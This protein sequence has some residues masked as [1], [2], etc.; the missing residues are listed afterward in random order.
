MT[1]QPQGDGWWQ[2]SDGRWYPPEQHPG[3]SGAGAGATGPGAGGTGTGVGGGMP[4]GD[5]GAPTP[6]GEQKSGKGK[7]VAAL[8][9][10]LLLIGAGVGAFVLLGGDD[11]DD[12][13]AT[14]S[15][16]AGSNTDIGD[17]TG[18]L[19][20]DG[21]IEFDTEYTDRLDGDRT[22]ARYTLDAPNGAIMTLEVANV[23]ES[24]R[25]VYVT[26]ESAGT[27]FAG[28][29]VQP[30]A[31][32]AE[33]II[34]DDT[35]EATFDLIFTEGPAEFTFGVGLEIQDDAGQGGDAGAEFASAFDIDAGQEVAAMLGGED[36]T[37]HFTV[38]IEPGT[39]L[40]VD[41]AVDR[42]S[43][44]A[45][46]MTVMLDGDRLF[47]ERVQPGADT[48][49]SMLL[50]DTDT[51]TLEVIATEGAADYTFTVDFGAQSEGGEDGDAPG[52]L[53]DARSIDISSALQGKVGDRD[54]AD[55]FT[56]TAPGPTFSVTGASDS[57]S[58]RNYSLTVQDA[59][60]GRVA[61]FRVQ[62]GA[63]NTETIEV[64]PGS[65][66][67]LIVEEGPASYTISVG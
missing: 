22:E 3:A 62:P 59:S 45:V 63:E 66:V 8:V 32:Q 54:S 44:R 39:E 40:T 12:E 30:G 18:E 46:Y 50:A 6:D 64:E 51:G 52:E 37:D 55:Y 34:L 24:E 1:D 4:A 14:Q 33:T 20:D 60:G 19:V 35:G 11:D 42:G 47:A 17:A 10:V 58:E 28:F 41:A 25:A 9:V 57:S 29:R 7:L 38:D 56:F 16:E 31:E 53:A 65:E 48:Q 26:F 21:P 23:A 2:A 43:E 67:R 36:D 5:Q 13:V 61:F 49:L 27:Q 15:D